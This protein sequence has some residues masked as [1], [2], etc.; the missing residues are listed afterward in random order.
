MIEDPY[1]RGNVLRL[2]EVYR[3]HT[4]ACA[5]IELARY[6]IA[7]RRWWRPRSRRVARLAAE[8]L[9]IYEGDAQHYQRAADF[10]RRDLGIT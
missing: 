8:A 10:L 1:V 5:R 4:A 2:A 7:Q 9:P 3:E 6:V